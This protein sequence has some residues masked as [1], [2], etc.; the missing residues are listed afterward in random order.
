MSNFILKHKKNHTPSSS[1]PLLPPTTNLWPIHI[2]QW[3]EHVV[4]IEY[5]RDDMLWRD[6]FFLKTILAYENGVLTD[7][8][9][10]IQD[11]IMMMIDENVG[12]NVDVQQVD[13]GKKRS[14]LEW[15]NVRLICVF[16]SRSSSHEERRSSR[17]HHRRSRSHSRS[18]KES[19]RKHRSS[20]SR[21]PAAEKK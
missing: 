14:W 21:S 4:L 15:T 7:L 6:D 3:H 10:R 11:E 13:H 19:K 18:K 8:G 16:R 9:R 20:S 12:R 2:V 5:H 1:S 17:R